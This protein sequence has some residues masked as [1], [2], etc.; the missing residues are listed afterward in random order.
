MTG[1]TGRSFTHPAG[2]HE[3]LSVVDSVS[4]AAAA[5]LTAHPLLILTRGGVE[6]D[7]AP[8]KTTTFEDLFA[9]M[10]FLFV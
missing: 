2:G 10:F 3:L 8:Q 6:V 1:G 4:A 9:K 7:S 5:R